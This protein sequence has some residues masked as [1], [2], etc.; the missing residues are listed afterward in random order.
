LED[1]AGPIK[2]VQ[3]CLELVNYQT[4]DKDGGLQFPGLFTFAG[5]VNG[6]GYEDLL[7][8]DLVRAYVYFNPLGAIPPPRHPFVRGDAN[9]DGGRDIGDAIFVLQYLFLTGR[10]PPCMDAADV[11]DDESI[12]IADAVNEL[13]WLFASG[14]PPPAPADCGPDPHGDTLACRESVC[15]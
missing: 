12:N 10:R 5:D 14:P 15:K 8:Y 6:D 13:T 3:D 4:Q 11:N 9:Q 1:K 7:V 2:E